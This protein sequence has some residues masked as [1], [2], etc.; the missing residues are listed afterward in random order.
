MVIF[1][2]G[3]D[4][5]IA[6]SVVQQK[7]IPSCVV[8]GRT[9]PQ[10]ETFLRDMQKRNH[11]SHQTCV[12]TDDWSLRGFELT[13]SQ[14][15]LSLGMSPIM[16]GEAFSNRLGR[17][18]KSIEGVQLSL[19]IGTPQE[20][21]KILPLVSAQITVTPFDFMSQSSQLKEFYNNVVFTKNQTKTVSARDLGERLVSLKTS[22]ASTEPTGSKTPRS[23]SGLKN[24]KKHQ[25]V[26][27]EKDFTL[28]VPSPPLK[29]TSVAGNDP[30]N[31][32]LPPFVGVK[33]SSQ[34]E[35]VEEW[36]GLCPLTEAALLGSMTPLTGEDE[37]FFVWKEQL[38][39]AFADFMIKPGNNYDGKGWEVE[40][41]VVQAKLKQGSRA[42]RILKPHIDQGVTNK[43]N[44]LGLLQNGLVSS[45]MESNGLGTTPNSAR[46]TPIGGLSDVA[47]KKFNIDDLV[48]Q[49]ISEV[50]EGQLV[51]S[52]REHDQLFMHGSV[53]IQKLPDGQKVITP[54]PKGLNRLLDSEEWK[55]PF[56]YTRRAFVEQWRY[57]VAE[58]FSQIPDSS[59]TTSCTWS[60][61]ATSRRSNLLFI[62]SSED[63]FR[64]EETRSDRADSSND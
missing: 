53:T 17:H 55:P 32:N 58:A 19:V 21:A 61:W 45:P 13:G 15:H 50:N 30:T 16:D 57:E 35:P 44:L 3:D 12:I 48:G 25:T 2:D 42:Y 60:Q 40:N 31:M 47:M 43:V 9:T 36:E 27:V 8:V 28:K 46:N 6:K 29:R 20:M 59:E 7:S 56:R 1:A 38:Y 23:D 14:V 34:R 26:R 49:I 10:Q 64:Q 22:P 41:L 11:G 51:P 52:P 63:L 39:T 5:E 4:Q 24:P 54:A 18:P 33:A 37:D 62:A